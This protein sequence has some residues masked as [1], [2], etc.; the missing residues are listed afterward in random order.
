MVVFADAPRAG[1]RDT[2]ER[3][4][5]CASAFWSVRTTGAWPTTA[6]KVSGRHRRAEDLI[7]HQARRASK[8]DLLCLEKVAVHPPSMA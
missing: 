3:C 1:E 7:A 2:R 8:V 4:G 5:S 6:S